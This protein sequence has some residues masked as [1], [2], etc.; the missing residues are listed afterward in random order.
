MTISLSPDQPQAILNE[1]TT[2]NATRTSVT[3]SWN[4]P[5]GDVDSYLI[6]VTHGQLGTRFNVIVDGS[7][8]V[9]VLMD[10]DPG[11]TYQVLIFSVNSNGLS[12][13]SPSHMIDTEGESMSL[14]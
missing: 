1:P 5:G 12:I 13:A 14:L 11:T 4:D 7:T 10:L 3:L 6:T 9:Y 8:T 2:V